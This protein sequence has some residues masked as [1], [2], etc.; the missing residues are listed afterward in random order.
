MK[1]RGLVLSVGF[2]STIGLCLSACSSGSSSAT[3]ITQLDWFTDEISSAAW[4]DLLDSCSEETGIEIVRESIPLKEVTSRVL[5][6]A[7]AGNLPDLVFIDNT[8]G[9]QLAE[10]GALTPLES[11]GLSS[12]GFLPGIVTAGT[13]E[14]ELYGLSVGVNTIALFY[15]TATLEEAGIE[16]PTTWAELRS[17]AGA[18]TEGSRYGFAFSAPASEEATWQYL[19]FLW[20]NGGTIDDVS[21]AQAVEALEYLNS[22]VQDGLTSASVVNWTQ[23]DVAD[24]FASG[25]VAMMVNGPWSIKKLEEAGVDFGIVSLPVPEAGDT[26][27]TPLGGDLGV[28]PVGDTE[29]QQAAATVLECMTSDSLMLERNN[30]DTRVPSKVVVAEEQAEEMPVM[31]AFVE[32]VKEAKSRTGE[33]G[34]GYPEAS[35][36]IRTAIQEV[37][38]GSKSAQEALDQ[39]ASEIQAIQ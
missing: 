22:F 25:N 19:P 10:T 37:L 3:S 2:V 18:L 11:L 35:V 34:V 13:W 14:D 7:S 31:A 39:A 12:D 15:D 38:T 17:A 5:Q 21:S 33:F 30:A 8:M 29:S 23:N 27:I 20:S 24:Q 36:A 16:P 1:R 32:S 4:Q 28:I 9:Q 26:L 6:G